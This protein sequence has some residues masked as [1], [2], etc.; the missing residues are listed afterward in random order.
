MSKINAFFTRH[1]ELRSAIRVFFYTLIAGL[2]PALL[3]FLGD[4]A[5]W[6]NDN[7][8]PFPEVSV[9]GKAAVSAVVAAL[10]GLIAFVYNKLPKTAT[11]RYD[12]PPKEG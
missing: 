5:Q 3:G 12:A 1:P 9:L 4:V 6:A 10:S 7:S 11:A 2:V 8:T